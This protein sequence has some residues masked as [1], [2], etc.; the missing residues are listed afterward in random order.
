MRVNSADDCY[1]QRKATPKNKWYHNLKFSISNYAHLQNQLHNNRPHEATNLG[2]ETKNFEQ[3]RI[4]P[5]SDRMNNGNPLSLE[6]ICFSKFWVSILIGS[7][8]SQLPTQDFQSSDCG[9]LSRFSSLQET[10][11]NEKLAIFST[12]EK[13]LLLRLIF[14]NMRQAHWTRSSYIHT[15]ERT[16]PRLVHKLTPSLPLSIREVTPSLACDLSLNFMR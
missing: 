7:V 13:R 3:H 9:G 16:H 4:V 5:N 6:P 12:I 1:I 11:S 2:G 15:Q 10:A 8:C 14:D